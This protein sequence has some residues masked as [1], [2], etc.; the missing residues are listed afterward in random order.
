MSGSRIRKIAVSLGAAIGGLFTGNLL[1]P[2]E[3]D[4]GALDALPFTLIGAFLIIWPVDHQLG[5]RIGHSAGR[6]IAITGLAAITGGV[7]LGSV[8][9]LAGVSQ[10]KALKLALIG[11]SYGAL[12]ALFWLVLNWVSGRTDRQ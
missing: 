4:Q 3:P 7:M 1:F 10:P 9:A 5:R 11:A 12:T 6:W 2:P 8:L